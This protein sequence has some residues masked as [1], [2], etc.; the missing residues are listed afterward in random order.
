M[1]RSSGEIRP[2]ASEN[3]PPPSATMCRSTI[4]PLSRVDALRVELLAEDAQLLV[5]RRRC[6]AYVV[7]DP[8]IPRHVRSHLVEVDAR[9]QRGERH[10]A[11]LFVERVCRDIG[12]DG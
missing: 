9:M 11:R 1:K 5:G 10:L 8:R 3:P 2:A 6:L 12:D 7:R 4:A